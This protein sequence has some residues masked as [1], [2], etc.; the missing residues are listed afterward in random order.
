MAL[1]SAISFVA[2]LG[3]SGCAADGAR[4]TAPT[5]AASAAEGQRIAIDSLELRAHRL[6]AQWDDVAEGYSRAAA[7]FRVAAEQF[8]RARGAGAEATAAYDA[9][10][11]KWKS[12]QESWV[13]YQRLVEIAAEVDASNMN[14]GRAGS[15]TDK[16]ECSEGMSTQAFRALLAS[17]GVDL[18]GKDIDHIVP[19]SL[20]GA[21][22]PWNYQVIDS[23][24]NRSMGAQWDAAKCAMPGARRCAEA[25]AAS[26]TCGG[27]TG[28]LPF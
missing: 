26:R 25:V 14:G 21:D 20:G 23:S 22:H 24:L 18:T 17:Q 3:L 11:R 19:K 1:R 15:R 9:A 8:E 28:P 10:E 7:N 5:S 2:A 13:F 6:S 27:F 4:A 16:P 12:A